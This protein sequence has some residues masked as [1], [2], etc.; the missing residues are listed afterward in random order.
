MTDSEE[1]ACTVWMEQLAGCGDLLSLELEN[2]V[3][4]VI[5]VK[6]IKKKCS[7]MRSPIYLL[8]KADAG[9]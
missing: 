2:A 5:A 7:A 3:V 8:S 9:I 1:E 6:T 4:V